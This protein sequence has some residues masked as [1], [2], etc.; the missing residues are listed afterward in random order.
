MRAAFFTVV[1][2]ILGVAP[3]SQNIRKQ[4]DQ[5][6]QL[7]ILAFK[8]S[9]NTI[10]HCPFAPLSCDPTGKRINLNT[11][12]QNTKKRAL[13]YTYKVSAG[14]IDGQGAAVI[15]DLNGALIGLHT[16]T[17]SISDGKGGTANASLEVRIVECTA[18]DAPPPPCPVVTVTCPS[19]IEN[20]KPITFT[21]NVKGD[22][23]LEPLLGDASYEW[24]AS[25][26]KIVK[27]QSEKKMTL[28]PAGFPFETITVT[29]SVGGFDPS[30]TGTQASCT[31]SIKSGP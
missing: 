3:S 13:T 4:G 19:E 7:S 20:R 2:F 18:C 28:E 30:C 21:A 31:I 14:T 10:S 1:A 25:S 11:T 9:V 15:W 17:V 16:A 27:G 23:V 26:G 5:K 24:W 8:S 29:V 6:N 12:V 22:P